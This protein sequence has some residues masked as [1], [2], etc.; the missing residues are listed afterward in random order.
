MLGGRRVFNG[1]GVP[2]SDANRIADAEA[3]AVFIQDTFSRGRWTVT[4]GVRVESIDLMRRDFGKS[5]P[6]RTGAALEARG[7]DLTEVIPGVGAEYRLSDSTR[8]FAGVHRG[9]SPPSPSSTQE[10][11]AEESVNYELGWRH[12]AGDTKAEIVGFYNDYDNLLG[13][14]TLSTGG[15]GTGDQFNGGEVEVNGIEAS[16]GIEVAARSAISSAGRVT[17]SAD[18]R[19]AS[20]SGTPIST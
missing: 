3:L 16:F 9:F 4:P 5:D 13:N 17:S 1:L 7:N 19:S 18:M 20:F 2:G 12:R 8:L 15:Q 10:V 6:E 11:G 14:D